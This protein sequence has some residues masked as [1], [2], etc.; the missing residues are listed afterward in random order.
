MV[1]C[2]A[3]ASSRQALGQR[4]CLAKLD[5]DGAEAHLLSGP[6]T[7]APP[8]IASEFHVKE[9]FA[10]RRGEDSFT[11]RLRSFASLQKMI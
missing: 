1:A 2:I 6:P 11:W 9:A 5:V 3:F 4:V 8:F 10:K 7:A